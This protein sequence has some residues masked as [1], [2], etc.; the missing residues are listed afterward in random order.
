[1]ERVRY[2]WWT[3][4]LFGLM[5]I[6]CII[7]AL[8]G[9]GPILAATVTYPVVLAALVCVAVGVIGMFAAEW[10]GRRIAPPRSPADATRR[11]NRRL[12]VMRVGIAA[13]IIAL[14]SAAESQSAIFQAVAF[15]LTSGLCAGGA[16]VLPFDKR[17]H[18]PLDMPPEDGRA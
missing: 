5:A 4:P 10:W 18:L 14:G 16:V 1:V 8:G 6:G 2:P 12:V 13:G 17:R 7:P 9:P 11:G 3:S 15:G